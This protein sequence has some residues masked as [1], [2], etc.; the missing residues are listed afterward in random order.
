LTKTQPGQ[1]PAWIQ[2]LVNRIQ[3]WR[4]DRARTRVERT[5]LQIKTHRQE[6]ITALEREIQAIEEEGT[7]RATLGIKR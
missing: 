3:L 5:E 6:T 7:M 2:W 1:R 4:L